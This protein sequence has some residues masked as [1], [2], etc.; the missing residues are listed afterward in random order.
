M[1]TLANINVYV[2]KKILENM[3]KATLLMALI[4]CASLN[5]LAQSDSG[6]KRRSDRKMTEINKIVKLNSQQESLVRNA[7][8][9]YMLT[10]DSSLY[11]EPDAVR[12]TQM[13]YRAN[14]RFHETLMN[15]LTEKQRLQYIQ[16]TSTPEVEAKTLYK[17][18][19]LQESG[20]YSDS[21]LSAMHDQIFDYLM[22][23]K[24]VYTRDKFN[25][26]KQKENISRLKNTQP[27]ALRESNTREKMKGQGRLRNGKVKW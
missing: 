8:E 3:K 19:L 12:A 24:V 26:K 15:T 7:Y 25:V 20:E 2:K 11:H 17:M 10:V 27:R 14:K 16:I 5:G 9:S 13:K 23:E 21:E 1:E 6:N 22:S 18:E 4:L